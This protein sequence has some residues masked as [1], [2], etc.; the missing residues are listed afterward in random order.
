MGGII[1][2]AEALASIRHWSECG[3]H[4][5][6]ARA[7]RAALRA[8]CRMEDVR[9]ARGEVKLVGLGWKVGRPVRNL[10]IGDVVQQHFGRQ[11]TVEAIIPHGPTL[12]MP[13]PARRWFDVRLF[14]HSTGK[15]ATKRWSEDRRVVVSRNGDGPRAWEV[16]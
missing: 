7:E 10:R 4:T 11:A 13:H 16:V 1:E 5:R 9:R 6:V 12:H 2:R 8:G 14:V 15:R 3:E